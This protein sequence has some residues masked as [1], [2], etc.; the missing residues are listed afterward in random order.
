MGVFLVRVVLADRPGALGAVASRIGSVR[1][2]VIGVE[3][4]ERRSGRAVDEFQVELAEEST[5]ELL[6]TEIEQV[7][8]AAVEQVRP[9]PQGRRDPRTQAYAASLSLM[10]ERSPGGLLD[11]LAVV[12]SGELDAGWSAVID[13]AAHSNNAILGAHGR[14]PALTW[15][16]ALAV[17]AAGSGGRA[18][19]GADVASAPLHNWDLLLVVGRP[20]WAFTA[21]EEERLRALAS[22]ADTRW[23]E[24][25]RCAHPTRIG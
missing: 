15:L 14:P 1:G 4:V 7:D 19:Q 22:L 12:A 24:L 3:I 6:V 16:T 23:V 5:V 8:G 25:A 21:T 13:M 20:G 18:G 11:R 10:D 9:L 17:D 2:D